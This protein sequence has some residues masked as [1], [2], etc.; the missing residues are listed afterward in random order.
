MIAPA[1]VITLAERVTTLPSREYMTVSVNVPAGTSRNA[2]RERPL[3]DADARSVLLS[4]MYG[5]ITSGLSPLL[6]FPAVEFPAVA[7]LGDAPPAAAAAAPGA[8]LPP[9]G[10]VVAVVGE[11]APALAAPA[12]PPVFI[13]PAALPLAPERAAAPTDPAVA[14]ARP[15][16]LAAPVAAASAAP[17][18]APFA[19]VSTSDDEALFVSF[20]EHVSV[21]VVPGGGRQPARSLRDCVRESLRLVRAAPPTTSMY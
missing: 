18:V 10:F 2:T 16:A 7:E 6:E 5:R 21:T 1:F 9:P 15:A 14:A 13:A 19:L 11:G 8:A 4:T 17:P 12:T 3:K 20:H